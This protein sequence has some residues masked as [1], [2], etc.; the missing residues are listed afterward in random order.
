MSGTTL[1]AV[2]AVLGGFGLA[3]VLVVP[4]I[5]WSYHRRGELGLG[6]AVLGLGFLI[7]SFALVTY[8]LLPLPE[9][10]TTFCVK[11]AA[12]TTPVLAPLRFLDDMHKYDTSGIRA[13]LRNPAL[14]QVLFN[15]ALF[16]PLG[17]FLRHLFRGGL[18]LTL[19]TGLLISLTVESTQLTGVWFLFQCPYR[20]FDTGDLL[21]NTLGA[22]VGFLLAPVLNLV[23]GQRVRVPMGVPRAVTRR[24]RLLGIALDLLAVWVA[25]NG[26]LFGAKLAN[27]ALHGEVPRRGVWNPLLT[28][29][30]AYWLPA[31]LLL[32]VAPLLG[33]GGTIG[34]RIVLLRPADRLGGVPRWPRV[35]LRFLTGSGGYFV[36]VGAAPDAALLLVCTSFVFLVHTTGGRGL[37]GV[38]AGLTVID[39]RVDRYGTRVA[40]DRRYRF[41][42]L[43]AEEHR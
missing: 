38:L 18:A 32:L 22:G 2:V 4:Y 16:V 23:P 3:A 25:G 9:V 26:L 34:Q 11:H 12:V 15:V 33:N 7:Y 8:T 39:S 36:L 13:V 6:H 1:S 19:S 40:H 31:V 43:P 42:H 20:L 5:A 10:D 27:W 41:E 14:R 35:V 21:S 28:S 37:S 29:V 30:L 17:M 24:R